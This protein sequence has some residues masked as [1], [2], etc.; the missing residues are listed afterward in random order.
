MKNRMS[1]LNDHLFAQLE[2]LNDEGAGTENIECEVKRAEAMVEVADQI[3]DVQRLNLD[4]A[5]LY[6]QHGEAI[7]PMLPR[8][9]RVE[10]NGGGE[11]GGGS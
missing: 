8:I 5:K 3:V 11:N 4:A 2:R 1:D 7:L 10:P 6:A 9:G